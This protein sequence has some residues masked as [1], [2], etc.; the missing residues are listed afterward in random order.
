MKKYVLKDSSGNYYKDIDSYYCCKD[1]VITTKNKAKAY[2]FVTREVAVDLM[3]VL[4][5]VHDHKFELEE[6]T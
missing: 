6:L 3:W 5:V 4:S 1:P 2:T